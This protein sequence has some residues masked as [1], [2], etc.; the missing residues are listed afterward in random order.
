M[1]LPRFRI[2]AILF[3]GFNLVGTVLTWIAH[4]QKPGTSL[5]NAIGS[6]TE[7]TG[8]IVLIAIGC[9]SLGLTFASRRFAVVVGIA[10]LG[11]W[12]LGFAVGESSELFKHNVGVSP[13]RWNVILAGSIIGLVLGLSCAVSSLLTLRRSRRPHWPS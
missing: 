13:D 2:V 5:T 6:G 3:V 8:P 10:L 9:L 12:G 11:L 1:T 7:F 4:L